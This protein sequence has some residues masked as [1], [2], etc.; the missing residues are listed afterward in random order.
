M[1]IM[2]HQARVSGCHHSLAVASFIFFVSGCS[3]AAC[4]G[5]VLAGFGSLLGSP[6][7]ESLAG[8][9]A[10]GVLA[11]AL[12]RDLPWQLN[13]DTAL[14]WLYFHD[15]RTAA[16]NG[17]ELGAGFPTR[18]GLWLWY[19]I[20]LGAFASGDPLAGA[21]IYGT[22]AAVRLGSS[23]A[24]AWLDRNGGSTSERGRTWAGAVRP[25]AGVAFFFALAFIAAAQAAAI[26]TT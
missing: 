11:G 5:L 13:R 19:A 15:W 22:Y 18:M 23:L 10:I 17:A 24:L 25:A 12:R 7:R 21:L 9:A 8:V 14:S 1:I 26:G 20:P 6:L 2:I 16:F 3:L 4:T